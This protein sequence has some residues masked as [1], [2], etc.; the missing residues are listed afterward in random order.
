[1]GMQWEGDHRIPDSWL[2]AGAS[3]YMST[4]REAQPSESVAIR[5]V[6]KWSQELL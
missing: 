1:M 2:L 4:N 6:W 5:R 3:F